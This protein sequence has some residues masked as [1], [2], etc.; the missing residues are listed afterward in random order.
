MRWASMVFK[1]LFRQF[2]IV[3]QDLDVAYPGKGK[4]IPSLASKKV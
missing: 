4:L 3:D 1:N 2:I